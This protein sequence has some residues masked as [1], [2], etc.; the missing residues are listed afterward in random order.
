MQYDHGEAIEILQKTPEVLRQLLSGLSDRWVMTNEGPDTFSPFDVMGH[1][2]I[3]EKTDW[4]P[5]IN[6]ILE[7]G[8]SVAFDTFDRFA[9]Y[10]ESA[11]KSMDDLLD[12]FDDLRAANLDWLESLQLNPGDLESKG[13]H[14]QLGEIS[15]QQLLAA[16]VVHDLTH[17]A[18]VARVMAKQ[19][20]AAIGPWTEFFRI[21]NF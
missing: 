2:V 10:R 9:M 5:R 21:L 17:I 7:H 4:R 1:L 6:R 8:N 13:T 3:G 18:Q 16:W 14:P 15:L 20:K 19:Y 11:G 12:E